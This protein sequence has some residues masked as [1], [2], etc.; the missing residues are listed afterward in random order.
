MPV[1]NAEYGFFAN[2]LGKD[3]GKDELEDILFNYG[4]E[5]NYEE[6]SMAMEITH[7]RP[8]LLS[9]YALAKAIRQ[10][11][12]IEKPE[13]FDDIK[14]SGYEIIVDRSVEEVR[15]FIAGFVAKDMHMDENKVKELVYLQEKL[16]ATF[17]SDRRIASIGLYVRDMIK[18]PIIYKAASPDEIS[19][20]PLNK[21]RKMNATEILKNH[22]T[23]QKYGHLLMGHK[24]YPVLLEG[25]GK[26]MSMAPIINSN[27]IGRINED[28]ENIFVEITGTN[29]NRVSQLANL[30]AYIF[31]TMGAKLESVKVKYSDKEVIY[32]QSKEREI[33]VKF[34]KINSYF[35]IK[36]DKAKVRE[37]LDRMGYNV[38]STSDDEVKVLVPFYRTDILHQVDVIEDMIKAYGLN[39]FELK[40]PTTY[41]QGKLLAKT[42]VVNYLRDLMIGLGFNEVFTSALSNKDTQYSAMGLNEKDYKPIEVLGAKSID[43]NIVRVS[44]IPEL[45]RLVHTNEH[46]PLPIKIFE[47]S[48]IVRHEKTESGYKNETKLS[49]LIYNTEATFTEA[50]QVLDYL[51]RIL[52][53][54]YSL[55][56]NNMQYFIEGRA[57][58]IIVNGKDI[59]ELGE[60]NPK[61][62]SNFGLK[63]PA[64]ALQIS[65]DFIN[66]ILNKA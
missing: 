28:T 9:I 64:V 45:L 32:P 56:D 38:E 11:L 7:D 63:A 60:I 29:F 5:V 19:F 6:N 37:L 14:P 18:S 66:S 33:S 52:G 58:H 44:I 4:I 55:E 31:Y 3:I 46:I 8:D 49:A 16:H 1:I 40:L 57:G 43:V 26:I 15:P 35:G 51:L 22:E 48:D 62:L 42:K 12:K 23:G 34:E 2:L 17:G 13:R 30:L 50:K 10:Y 65:I 27:D 61:V 24:K 54:N 39:N 36:I 21:E 25:T 20:V 47:I 59:G 53:I 41:T